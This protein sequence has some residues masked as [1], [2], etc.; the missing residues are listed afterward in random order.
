[1][2]SK[3]STRPGHLDF[4]HGSPLGAVTR[5]G[6]VVKHDVAMPSPYRVFGQFAMVYLLEGAGFYRDARGVDRRVQRGDLIFVFPDVPHLYG[7]E[8]GG[9]WVEYYLV[10]EGPLVELWQDQGLLDPNRPLLH[11]EPVEHWW[12]RLRDVAE[13]N[14]T[15]PR[16]AVEQISRLQLVLA[17]MLVQSRRVR[18]RSNAWLSKARMLLESPEARQ[19]TVGEIAGQ[20]HMSEATLRR[21]FREATGQSPFQYRD[22]YLM[23]TAQQ[24]MMQGDWTDQEIGYRLGMEDPAYFS[25][26]FT[27]IVGMTPTQYK[28]RLHAAQLAYSSETDSERR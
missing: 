23:H 20:L 22:E 14:E 8:A 2:Q 26:R 21:R 25:R 11:V 3:L 7:P 15:R 27:Q 4:E 24:M 1:M 13:V 10:F 17:E 18:G 12:R 16:S 6:C 19:M 28:R 5:V 9:R